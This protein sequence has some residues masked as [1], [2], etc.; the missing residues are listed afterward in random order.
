MRARGTLAR[1]RGRW[2]DDFG[3][4]RVAM[5]PSQRARPMGFDK[6]RG[7]CGRWDPHS[8]AAQRPRV[9]GAFVETTAD[10]TF[11]AQQQPAPLITGCR[12]LLPEAA[13]VATRPSPT[14]SAVAALRKLGTRAPW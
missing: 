1:A 12:R 13:A 14:S 4:R 7:E 5:S 8:P 9:H 11:S 2:D 10:S 3:C 6:E